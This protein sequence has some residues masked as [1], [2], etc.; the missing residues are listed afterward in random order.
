VLPVEQLSAA[1]TMAAAEGFNTG[2]LVRV[3]QTP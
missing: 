1:E 2:K 3:S